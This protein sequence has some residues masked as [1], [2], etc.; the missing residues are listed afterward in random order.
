MKI[1]I[2][3][4]G[5]MG[6]LFGALLAEAG[7]QVTLLDIRQDHVDAVN[8]EGLV[9]EKEGTRRQ[10]RIRATQDADSIG[11]TDLCIVFVKSTQTAEAARTVA[12]L[13]GPS[14]LV[15]TLQN[16]MGNAEA[17]AEALDPARIIAGTT[18]HGATF[19]EP[20]AIRH[21][22]SGDTVIG[23]WDS[24]NMDGATA[25]A[26]AFDQ[27]GIATKVVA[28]VHSVMWAKLFINVG[29]NAITALTGIKNGQLLDLEQTR[30]LSQDAVKEA[31]AVAA[32]RGIAIEGD[33]V[34]KVFQVAEATGAN[35]SS[36]GQDVDSRRVTEI[37]AING[38]IVREAQTAGV[39]APVNRTL[40][41]LV[42]T[43]QAH[44]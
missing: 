11:P 24:E 39:P 7:Q 14:T 31:M 33:P 38:F 32:A 2:I 4:A 10:I 25:V 35:R 27:A 23:P 9:V 37:G 20:G 34:E 12:R 18:S 42:E 5:A 8:A 15:L 44:Y 6:S 26:E 3:G 28:G 30:R 41:A 40:S 17:L 36:M 1:A 19:L 21:A 16:G 29:I 13:A 22:G 43:L